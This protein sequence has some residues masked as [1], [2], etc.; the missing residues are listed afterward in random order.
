MNWIKSIFKKP[1]IHFFKVEDM[2]HRDET[3]YLKWPCSKCGKVFYEECGLDV[4]KHG[5]CDGN[6]CNNARKAK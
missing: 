5:R 3:G 2:G 1:C 6:W 4:L